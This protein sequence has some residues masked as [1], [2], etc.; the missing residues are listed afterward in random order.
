V[1]LSDLKKGM[2]GIVIVQ[3]TP[4]NKDGSLDLEGM[5][6]NTRW[7]LEYTAGKEF[8]YTPMGSTGEFYAMSD[9][10]R[11]AVIKMVVEEV[12]G[13]NIVLP[14]AAQAAT[15]ETIKMC[16]Y[17]ESVGADGVQ[18][19]LPYYL[20]PTEEGM[21]QHY[22]QIAESVGKDF[23]I[24][25]YNNPAVSGSWV[26]PPLMAKLSKI[27]NVISLKENTASITEYYAMQRAIDPN[28]MAILCGLGEQMFSFESL[29]G[30]VGFISGMANYAPDV[31][32]SVYKAAAAK[33]F[34]K[35]AEL[36]RSRAPYSDF[37][38]KVVANHGPDTAIPD[39]SGAGGYMIYPVM[40]ASM[41]IVGLRGG[42]VRLPL[43]NLTKEEKD[44]LKDVMK[45]MP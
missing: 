18:V 19:V 3:A 29:Y 20:P 12:K 31:S 22:K 17:A 13:K 11:K 26:K 35:L 4:F 16:Q 43:V 6:A 5:R 38:A 24:M 30:C 33:D 36:I 45:A 32:Y 28:D 25:V 9:D 34:S 2:K 39:V 42:D 40:K 1:Q 23:G 7:L 8:I 44:E 14:G 10:E 21:Y 15:R 27:P 41:D 37:V